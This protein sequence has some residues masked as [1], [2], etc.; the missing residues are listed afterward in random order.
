MNKLI[1][2]IILNIEYNNVVLEWIWIC[3][4]INEDYSVI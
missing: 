4:L 1:F 3:L 2:H